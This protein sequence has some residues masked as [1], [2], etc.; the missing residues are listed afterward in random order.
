MPSPAP[1]SATIPPPTPWQGQNASGIPPALSD[2]PGPTDRPPGAGGPT[3]PAASPL[4]GIPTLKP[5][6]IGPD[7]VRFPIT[8]ATALRLS[9]A[10][11][12]IVAMAQAKIWIA[13]ADLTQAKVLW[14]PDLNIG[15]DYI[16]HDGG[17]PDFNK[18]ILTTPST[19]FFYG[20]AGLWGNQYG[21]IPIP[22]AIYQPLVARQVLNSRHWDMQ[23]AKND[24]V[25]QTADAYF[26]VHQYRGSYTGALYTVE[27]ARDVVETDRRSE[28]RPGARLR[29]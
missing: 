24:A 14:V 1:P 5:A 7:D 4:G 10:R 19:N 16:R 11:P 9:D 26:M 2:Q 29:G 3:P 12:L 25:L 8:L 28:P 15:A 17:G 22:D 23:A 18:G 21:I 6:P 20:G 13:E 27:R